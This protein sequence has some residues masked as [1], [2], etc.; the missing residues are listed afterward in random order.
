MLAAILVLGLITV[1]AQAVVIGHTT[2]YE[3]KYTVAYMGTTTT[4]KVYKLTLDAPETWRIGALDIVI[5]S[6][7]CT[8]GQDPFQAWRRT[9]NSDEETWGDTKTPTNKN[10]KIF[11]T[12]GSYTGTNIY[13]TDTRL[14]CDYDMDDP[15]YGD[16]NMWIDNWQP[17]AVVAP[18]ERNDKSIYNPGDVAKGELGKGDLWVT[19]GIPD[20]YRMQNQVVALI[21]IVEGDR[22]WAHNMSA[23]QPSEGSSES[24]DEVFEII[25][26]PATLT[27]LGL[28]ALALIRRRRT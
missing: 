13:E 1:A 22:V 9:Y 26:E 19:A 7:A 8:S 23:A 27:V 15:N 12:S 21:G 16:S 11:M 10:D 6:D 5:G 14:I 17:A 2:T 25:P 20:G 28:G 24:V 4:V 18:S 3:G